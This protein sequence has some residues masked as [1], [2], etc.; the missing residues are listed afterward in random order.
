MKHLNIKKR[1]WIGRYD[2]EGG[3]IGSTEPNMVAEVESATFDL[4]CL[5]YELS[6]MLKS[7]EDRENKGEYIDFQEN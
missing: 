6:S 4:A 5:K 3:H 7:I 1:T 2:L